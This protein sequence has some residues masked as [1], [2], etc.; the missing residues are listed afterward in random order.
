MPTSSQPTPFQTYPPFPYYFTVLHLPSDWSE[1]DVVSFLKAREPLSSLYHIKVY[2]EFMWFEDLIKLVSERDFLFYLWYF[3]ALRKQGELD[4]PLDVIPWTTKE[5]ME[6]SEAPWDPVLLDLNFHFY[7]TGVDKPEGYPR[8]LLLETPAHEHHIKATKH[9]KEIQSIGLK[10]AGGGKGA[11]REAAKLEQQAFNELQEVLQEL[12]AAESTFMTLQNAAEASQ[13]QKDQ[14][15]T[16]NTD[17]KLS[18]AADTPPKRLSRQK[19]VC[20]LPQG[21]VRTPTRASKR[22]NARKPT[23]PGSAARSLAAA[24]P[25]TEEVAQNKKSRS[26]MSRCTWRAKVG[27]AVSLFGH[28]SWLNILGTELDKKDN[29]APLGQMP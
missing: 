1:D 11:Q 22:L 8:W 10:K 9:R 19:S 6:R 25:A 15:S 17:S 13:K 20:E 12:K 23:T 29:M 16:E 24:E 21:G 2:E 27:L 7:V 26:W 14:A 5:I 3:A 4:I 28:R 18:P